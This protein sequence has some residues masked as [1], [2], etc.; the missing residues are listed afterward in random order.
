MA[1]KEKFQFVVNNELHEHKVYAYDRELDWYCDTIL[2]DK[3]CYGNQRA[4]PD[5]WEGRKF[6]CSEGCAYLF[7]EQCVLNNL[8]NPK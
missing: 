6:K 1:N 4:V 5:S 2:F 8:I 7:C 3:K